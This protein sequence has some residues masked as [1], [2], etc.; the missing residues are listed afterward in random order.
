MA[1]LGDLLKRRGISRTV[2]ELNRGLGSSVT[3]SV[4]ITNT[5]SIQLG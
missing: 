4:G 2:F 3:I 5:Y 1:S